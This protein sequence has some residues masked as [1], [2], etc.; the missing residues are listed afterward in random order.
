V[1]SGCAYKPLIGGKKCKG[2]EGIIAGGG[3]MI[4]EDTDPDVKDTALISAAQRAEHY[5]MAG[6]GTGR[7][8]AQ[9]PGM[10]DHAR[11]LQQTLD[12]EGMTDKKL[13]ALTESGIN[14]DAAA[15]A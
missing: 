2:I 7:A 1:F 4:K 12:E 8:Y 11:V 9:L 14:R 15:G 13:T 10:Q 5:E 3:E 6:Y